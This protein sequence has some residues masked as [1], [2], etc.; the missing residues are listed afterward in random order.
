ME[1][2]K[3]SLITAIVNKGYS[4]AV[5]EAAKA[6]GA[7]GG[8][9]IR[10]RGTGELEVTKFMGF[11]IEPEKD[12]VMILV[13]NEKRTA[14]MKAIHTKTGLGTSGNGIAFALPVHDVL[15]GFSLNNQED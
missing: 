9:V 15:G 11:V 1:E 7:S 10:A 6:E 4:D 13:E 2:H 8:T 3:Y 5:M 12:L 14:I